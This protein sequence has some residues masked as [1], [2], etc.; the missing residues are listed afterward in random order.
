VTATAIAVEVLRV[1]LV[2]VYPFKIKHI[3]RTR[4]VCPF[5]Y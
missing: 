3:N 5:D 1:D 4:P 2:I